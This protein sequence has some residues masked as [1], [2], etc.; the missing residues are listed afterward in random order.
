MTESAFEDW[1]DE[2]SDEQYKIVGTYLY[3]IPEFMGN[4]YRAVTKTALD[5]GVPEYVVRDAVQHYTEVVYRGE[6]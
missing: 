5:F 6:V 4:S 1:E 2:A 3:Y